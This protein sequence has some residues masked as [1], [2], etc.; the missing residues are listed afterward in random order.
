VTDKQALDMLEGVKV[1]QRFKY[2]YNPAI[3]V[4]FIIWFL[5]PSH[6]LPPTPLAWGWDLVGSLGFWLNLIVI[7]AIWGLLCL[8]I[9]VVRLL[10][11]VEKKLS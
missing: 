8:M 11:L 1:N 6:Y 3:V 4:A 5:I 2:Q 10:F 7:T 9:K